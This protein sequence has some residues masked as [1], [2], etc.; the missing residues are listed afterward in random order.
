[1]LNVVTGKSG[2][3]G[4]H[5]PA[6]AYR[7]KSDLTSDL[8]EEIKL[9][10]KSNFNIIHCAAIVGNPL[11]LENLDYSYLINVT[12]TIELARLSLNAGVKKFVYVSTSHVYERSESLI[13]EWSKISPLSE[14]AHQKREAEVKLTE[15][16]KH[17]P[18]QLLIARVFSL[19][20]WGMKSSTL[21]GAI[22]KLLLG[23]ILSIDCGDDQ[24]DFLTPKSTAMMLYTLANSK[25][26]GVLNVCS[27][28]AIKIKDAVAYMLNQKD[29]LDLVSRVREGNSDAP[30]IVGDNS[31][32]KKYIKQHDFVWKPQLNL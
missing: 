7:F 20:D 18:Q 6:D 28:R 22:E 32:L 4:R 30:F 29:G 5:F 14:Y 10:S 24:R 31:E 15:V 8:S 19:L 26:S 25:A 27:S 2:T 9:I 16:F 11:V 3:I 1:M 21:G 17:Y 12:K 23:E 13:N